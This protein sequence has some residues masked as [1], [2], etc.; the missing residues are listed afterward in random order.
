MKLHRSTICAVILALSA[1]CINAFA[2][3]HADPMSVT[4]PFKPQDD[5]VANI[6]D[7]HAFVV[8]KDR[9]PVLDEARI[10][11]SDQ[12]I[13]SLCVRRRLLPWQVE[14][15]GKDVPKYSFRVH[16]D[17]NPE[18][19]FFDPAK[20]RGGEDYQA[21]IAE[22]GRQIAEATATRDTT[23][24]AVR[25]T[26]GTR[27]QAELDKLLAERGALI[28]EHQQDESMQRLYGGIIANPN[29][30]AEEALLDFRLKFSPDGENSEASLDKARIEG[31]AGATN[32][33]VEGRKS[34]D[35]TRDV[36]IANPW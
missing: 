30:I 33:V 25:T 4:N 12:L 8:D 11:E 22:L 15:I 10:S 3:D 35:G 16:L 36:V 9:K 19:R 23:Q 24:Q 18:M 26:M 13:I 6:T 28:A 32:M 7:L 14:G 34:R 1:I 31:I 21:K 5:P 2:S 20:T 17:L 29:T 27:S